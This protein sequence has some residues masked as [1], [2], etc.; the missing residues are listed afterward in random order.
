MRKISSDATTAA[1]KAFPM[2]PGAG[3]V[4]MFCATGY[5]WTARGGSAIAPLLVLALLAALV[6]LTRK[7]VWSLMDEVYDDG[8]CLIVKRGSTED[9]L[10]FSDIEDAIDRSFSRPSKV[11]L[12]MRCKSKFGWSIAFVPTTDKDVLVSAMSIGREIRHR[13]RGAET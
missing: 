8:N 3:L 6:W 7:F 11:V 1:A 13:S 12:R 9:K 2:L 4:F 5:E 10:E